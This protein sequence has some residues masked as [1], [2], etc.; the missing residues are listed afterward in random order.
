MHRKTHP[1]LLYLIK[2]WIDDF[3]K[4][5]SKVNRNPLVDKLSDLKKAGAR[6]IITSS[7]IF[8]NEKQKEDPK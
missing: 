5:K 6:L 3:R 1:Y 2:I 8:K 4:I 7:K